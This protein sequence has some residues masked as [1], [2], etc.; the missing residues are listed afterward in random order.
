M[1]KN[2]AAALIT[3][4]IVVAL[5]AVLWSMRS[6]PAAPSPALPSFDYAADDSWA[7]KP[8]LPPPAVW[9]TGW[10]I[11]VVLLANGEALET[12]DADALIKARNAAAAELSKLSAAL[13]PVGPVYAPL[14]RAAETENDA[15]AAL[16]HYLSIDNRGRA[17]I[18]VT[19]APLPGSLLP[20]L[21]ADP[22]LRDRFGGV[23]LYGEDAAQAASASAPGICSRR[24]DTA[25][26][27]IVPVDLRRTGGRYEVR[28]AERLTAGFV[29]WLQGNSSKLAEP[30]GDL[31]EI[32]IIAIQRPPEP[33]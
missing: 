15:A 28:G 13:E 17:F 12:G 21:D 5:G 4:L 19:D 8:E 29:A 9:E 6:T 22:L 20:V 33:E 11:D 7:V 26:G 18:L 2:F 10:E 32:E 1:K 16:T 23:L 25:D 3:G 30:L 24:F 31:E 27:C 14:L